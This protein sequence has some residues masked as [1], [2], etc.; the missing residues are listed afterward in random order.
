VK[1]RDPRSFGISA[2]LRTVIDLE[3]SASD[4]R[5][6]VDQRIQR[7]PLFVASLN[8]RV[9][10]LEE[11]PRNGVDLPVPAL[12]RL[13]V[14]QGIPQEQNA[15]L[16]EVSQLFGDAHRIKRRLIR[17]HRFQIDPTKFLVRLPGESMA[18]PV[19]NA[20][21]TTAGEAVSQLHFDRPMHSPD[22][23]GATGLHRCHGKSLALR[24]SWSGTATAV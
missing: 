2:R 17:K 5:Q 7:A 3:D 9:S 18:Q 4:H 10:G 24:G 19:R 14:A 12:R 23:R 6:R 13:A 21:L 22:P 16:I 8:P 11:T 15:Q 1:H 20:R